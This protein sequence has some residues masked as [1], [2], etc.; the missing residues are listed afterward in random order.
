MNALLLLPLLALGLLGAHFY[1]AAAWPLV[2]HYRAA[3][4]A[5][6]EFAPG[7]DTGPDEWAHRIVARLRG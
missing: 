7:P 1:R 6:V 3:G 2:D 4:A 5:I